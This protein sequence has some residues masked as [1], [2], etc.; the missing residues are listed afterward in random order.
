MDFFT[1]GAH[2]NHAFDNS[3]R[4]EADVNYEIDHTGADTE[5][6]QDFTVKASPFMPDGVVDTSHYRNDYSYFSARVDYTYQ[7][8]RY[9][10]EAGVSANLRTMD[11]PYH[12]RSISRMPSPIPPLETLTTSHFQIRR[13]RI[14]PLPYLQP[15]VRRADRPRLVAGRILEIG[16]CAP[17]SRRTARAVTVTSTTAS[18][19]FPRPASS[20]G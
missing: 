6:A 5:F 7:R 14:C 17:C 3:S 9:K 20:G 8:D 16:R 19:C 1:T 12:D 10:W 13:R 4:L 11:N 15:H 18:T 2:L